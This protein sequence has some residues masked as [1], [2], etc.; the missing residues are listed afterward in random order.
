MRW[1][2]WLCPSPGRLQKRPGKA[3]GNTGPKWGLQHDTRKGL[4]AMT[5]LGSRQYPR[6]AVSG[7]SLYFQANRSACYRTP[8]TGH[9]LQDR[10]RR[11]GILG[12]PRWLLTADPEA[13]LPVCTGSPC[14]PSHEGVGQDN[15]G[16]PRWTPTHAQRP[17]PRGNLG[18]LAERPDLSEQRCIQSRISQAPS[19]GSRCCGLTEPPSGPYD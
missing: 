2:A 17:V 18:N 12:C 6:A 10:C 15:T 11:Q 7:D 19:L 3:V 8:V 5:L 16:G 13:R 4:S 1:D 9:L 14:P